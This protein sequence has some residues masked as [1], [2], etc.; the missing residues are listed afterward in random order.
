MSVGRWL[1]VPTPVAEGLL[2]IA[3][4]VADRPLYD[5]GRTLESLGLARYSK[6]QLQ[7]LLQQ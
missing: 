5:E 3:T 6:Q 2:S 1:G 7:T 4:P